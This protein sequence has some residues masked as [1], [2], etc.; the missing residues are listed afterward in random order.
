MPESRRLYRV[1]GREIREAVAEFGPSAIEVTLRDL[2]GPVVAG[3]AS[4]PE[5]VRLLRE[6]LDVEVSDGVAYWTARLAGQD[7]P[8]AP[9]DDAEEPEEPVEAALLTCTSCGSLFGRPAASRGRPRTRCY[10]CSPPR[11]GR[12]DA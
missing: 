8:D 3:R 2:L 1:P 10:S 6:W 9:E 5:E 4:T 12:L 7:A 11:S